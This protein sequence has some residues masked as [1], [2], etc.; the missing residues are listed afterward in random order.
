MARNAHPLG[1]IAAVNDK[2]AVGDQV[3]LKTGGPSLLVNRVDGQED[4]RRVEC[5]VSTASG[6]FAVW[7]DVDNL[8]MY[9]NAV[10]SR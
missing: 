10:H 6:L 7:I 2:Y 4:G 5:V 9:D 3:L 1:N 8:I